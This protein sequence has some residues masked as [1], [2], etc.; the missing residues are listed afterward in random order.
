MK[1]TFTPSFKAKN[2]NIRKADDIQRN[3]RN[4]FPFAS[5]T[6]FDAFYKT[7]KLEINETQDTDK[8][9]KTIKKQVKYELATKSLDDKISAIRQYSKI[10]AFEGNTL[11]EKNMNAPIFLIL[12]GI[13][14]LKT[15]NCQECAGLAMAAL[16]ANGITNLERD[17]V[18]AEFKYI[19]KETGQTEYLATEDLD[20]TVVVAQMG[21]E[22]KDKVVVDAWIGFADSLSASK[23]KFKQLL[24]ESDIKEL[25]KKHSE[26]FKKQ[27]SQKPANIE[28]HYIK[29]VNINFK[30]IEKLSEENMRLIGYYTRTLY[31]ELIK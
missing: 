26:L 19:N 25:E 6:Y 9:L 10:K 17:K 29:K 1:I 2:S 22:E 18:V 16:A 27:K 5:P 12:R 23:A 21:K 13:K 4:I 11:E 30:Q 14:A 15:A 28:K 31:P 24:W 7:G 8:K 3:A 20:H